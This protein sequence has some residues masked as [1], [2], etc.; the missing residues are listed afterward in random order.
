MGYGLN[1]TVVEGNLF[2][3]RDGEGF[4]GKWKYTIALDMRKYCMQDRELITPADAVL[5][6]WQDGEFE[7]VGQSMARR[8]V[9]PE[10]YWLVVTQ[11]YFIRPDGVDASYPVMV[12][13]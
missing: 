5:A 3:R 8:P 11:P 6:A 1:D 7:G 12:K 2:V 9:G 10:G 4:S 13:V